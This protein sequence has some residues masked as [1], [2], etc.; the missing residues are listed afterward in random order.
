MTKHDWRAQLSPDERKRIR[1]IERAMKAAR[2]RYTK[3]V[4]DLR[5]ERDRIQNTA[6]VRARRA[7]M[8]GK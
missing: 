6:S 4:H 8:D 1:E 3:E 2:K 7:G 5:V